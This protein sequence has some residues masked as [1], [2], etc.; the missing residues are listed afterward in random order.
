MFSP[1]WYSKLSAFIT[2][3]NAGADCIVIG[4]SSFEKYLN[5]KRSDA[6]SSQDEDLGKKVLVVIN[7][8]NF[9]GLAPLITKVSPHLV[10][11]CHKE[12]PWIASNQLLQ[13]GL[14][15]IHQQSAKGR[16]YTAGFWES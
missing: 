14:R 8:K 3:D 6:L 12:Q 4:N 10:V 5:K 7:E 13:N 2:K 11:L 15:H 9:D 16:I 1:A